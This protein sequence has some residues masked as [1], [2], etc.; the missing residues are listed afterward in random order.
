MF[1]FI[2]IAAQA[3]SMDPLPKAKIIYVDADAGGTANGLNWTNAYTSLQD[4]LST[5]DFG[6][7]KVSITRTK[8]ENKRM[9]LLATPS[10]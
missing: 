8:A 7:R 10:N 4:A 1:G 6:L 5:A 9:M 2:R 3:N